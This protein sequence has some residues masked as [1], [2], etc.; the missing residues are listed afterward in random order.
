M[1]DGTLTDRALKLFAVEGTRF[2]RSG[3][4]DIDELT[5]LVDELQQYE[6]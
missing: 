4:A 5:T 1:P 3:T 6:S 2:R